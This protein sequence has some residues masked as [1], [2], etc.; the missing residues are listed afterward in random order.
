MPAMT[1]PTM[2]RN[3][4]ATLLK[5]EL[6]KYIRN[7]RE[8]MGMTQ[9]DLAK[10]VGIEYFTAISAIELGRNTVPPERYADFARALDIPPMEF[11]DTVLRLTNPW[12]HAMLRSPSHSVADKALRKINETLSERF[13]RN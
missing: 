8:K 11:A 2:G 12:A 13:N 10:A 1:K 9:S 4:E 5:L 3:A 6:G 7:A